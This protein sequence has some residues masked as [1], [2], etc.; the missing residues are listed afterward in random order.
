MSAPSAVIKCLNLGCGRRFHPGWT[1]VDLVSSS[2]FVREC[3]LREGVPFSGEAFD[4]VY[5]S[6]VLE[7]FSRE[8]APAFLR[9]CHRVLRPGGFLR[10]AVPD[11]EGIARN[12]LLALDSARKGKDGWDSNYDWML[13]EL[14]DQAVREHSG[15]GWTAY[16]SQ[17]SIPNWH[18][19]E[20]RVGAE[21]RD[22]RQSLQAQTAATLETRLHLLT[23]FEFVIR[24]FPAV[25]KDK[26]ARALLSKSEY[27]SPQIVRFRRSGEI[28]EWMYDS[29]S[30]ARLLRSVGFPDPRQVAATESAIPDWASYCLD[31]EPDGSTYKPDSLFM[32]ARK[33]LAA[34]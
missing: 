13:L 18:F 30:L 10:V 6:H 7:H 11:L 5:H 21:A 23:R 29:Y 14:Y 17:E 16:L 31:N 32:E 26:L 15:G 12:Y 3:N 28:H 33:P 4:V 25:M 20:E 27:E 19:V 8:T 1:N 9:E 24:N 22:M 2:R 34:E